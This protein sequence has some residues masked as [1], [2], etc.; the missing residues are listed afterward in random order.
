MEMY[1]EI[2]KET[3]EMLLDSL[4]DRTLSGKQKWEELDYKPISFVREDEDS[5]N[6]A[7]ISQMFEMK[8]DFNGRQ[9]VLEVMEQIAFPSGKGDISG[10]ITFNGD[11]WGKYDFALSFDERYDENG[12]EQLREIFADSVIVKLMETV[13]TVFEGTEAESQGFSYARYYCQKG[14]EPKWKQMPL[15]KIGEKL[16]IEK[17]MRDFHRIVLDV[18]YREELL[19]EIS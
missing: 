19:K 6:E 8:I 3:M 7:F 1:R 18:D 12:L 14:I 10:M 16:M 9:Y 5:E 13:V 2:D 4:A 11:Q 17:R 15:V